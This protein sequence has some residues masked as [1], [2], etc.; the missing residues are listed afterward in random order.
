MRVFTEVRFLGHVVLVSS[1]LVDLGKVEAVMNWERLNSVFE[2]RSFL[3]LTRYYKRF[4]ED[5]FS[6]S[7][8]Y[9]EIE[10]EGGQFRVK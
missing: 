5:F 9:D 8:T 3:G 2:I 6:I 4:I 10:P 1:V 7:C